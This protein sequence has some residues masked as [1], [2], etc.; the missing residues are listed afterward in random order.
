MAALIGQTLGPY[1]MIELIGQ[2]AMATIYKA[3]HSELAC[4][5]AVKILAT[6][7]AQ[8]SE[9][10][11][12]FSREAHLMAQLDHPHILPCYDFGRQGDIC[13]MVLKYVPACLSDRLGQPLP[14]AE[15]LKIAQQIADALDFA[16]GRGILHCDVKPA[17]ILIDE[18]GWIYLTHWHQGN[19]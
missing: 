15:A 9:I 19:K 16:H 1:Q 13:Y 17:N 11:E 7:Y 10:R 5:V 14:L 2:G 6:D 12:S 8:E 4:Y 18:Q 3:Y